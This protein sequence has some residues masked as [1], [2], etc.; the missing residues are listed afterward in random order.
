MVKRFTEE[1]QL[2][3]VD[4]RT[5]AAQGIASLTQKLEGFKQST[6]QVQTAIGERL[7][8]EEAAGVE[9][10]RD[11]ITGQTKAPEKRKATVGDILLTGGAR[12]AAFNKTVRDGY[13]A[14]LENDLRLDLSKIEQENPDN[15]NIFNEKIEGLRSGTLKSVDPSARQA[16]QAFLDKQ[17]TN[18]RIRIQGKT[19]ERQRQEANASRR[20]AIESAGNE[21]AKFAREGDKVGAAD[22]LQDLFASVDGMVETGDL[23]T[24]EGA[25]F[26][27]EAEKEATEQGF[28]FQLDDLA[29]TEGFDAAFEDLEAIRNQVPKG[30]TPDEWDTFVASAQ[31]DLNGKAARQAKAKAELSLETSRDISNLKIQ[32]RTG[33]GEPSDIIKKTEDFFNAGQITEAERT[34]IITE[35]INAQKETAKVAVSKQKVA[36]RLSGN[37]EVVVDQND[38]DLAW[39]QDI[40]PTVDQLPPEQKNAAIAQFVDDTK[41]IP[42]QV[43]QQVTSNLN[44]LDPDLVVESASLIDRLDNVRGI[45]EDN[46]SSNERAFAEIVVGLQKNLDPKEALNLARKNTDPNDRSRVDMRTK[47][48]KDEEFADGYRDEVNDAFDPF[49]GATRVDPINEGKLVNEYK[50]LFEEHF[51]AGMSK[52]AADRKA[53][54]ILK[55]NW[56][57]TAVTGKARAIKYPPEDYYTVAG[58]TEYMGKQLLAD[59]RKEFIFDRKITPD[60]LRVVADQETA[61]TATQGKP[62]YMIIVDLGEDGLSPLMGFRWR[63]DMQG[64]IDRQS[65]AQKERLKELRKPGGKIKEVAFEALK[66]VRSF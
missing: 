32:A 31:A 65:L 45:P 54:E 6:E 4:V 58:N 15:I 5:G 27:R 47:I 18:S 64:E 56:G 59:V 60:M 48:I 46:F 11:P 17:I 28:R 36:N 20:T 62:S 51:K 24:D 2:G 35:V 38:V 1:V 7:G 39:E 42:T 25:E 66:D 53:K 19:I 61:R 3:G 21:A 63:P 26:K 40:A 29:E 52:E 12:T 50:V 16:V 44:S 8:A 37:A 14:S 55:R 10:E 57:E 9:F 13:L 49:F 22:A 41:R 33:T 30:W 43:K 34:S 23:T